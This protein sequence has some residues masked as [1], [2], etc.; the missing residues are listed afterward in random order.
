MGQPLF[1]LIIQGGQLLSEKVY[2]YLID[3]LSIMINSNRHWPVSYFHALYPI[4]K[5]ITTL[6]MS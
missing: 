1:A 5:P 2:I 6:I 4:L 3:E